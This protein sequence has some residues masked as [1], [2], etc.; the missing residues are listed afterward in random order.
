MTKEELNKLI[1][2]N[3]NIKTGEPPI[4]GFISELV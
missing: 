2:L 3:T 4:F 1:I